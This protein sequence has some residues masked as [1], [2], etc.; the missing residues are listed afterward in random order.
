MVG[1]QVF[2]GPRCPIRTNTYTKAD[3]S[4]CKKQCMIMMNKG[5]DRFRRGKRYGNDKYNIGMNY[6]TAEAI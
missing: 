1:F 6:L 4:A 2:N 3:K 5:K